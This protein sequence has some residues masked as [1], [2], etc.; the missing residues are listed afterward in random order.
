M[1][2]KNAVNSRKQDEVVYKIP[3]ECG[4]MYTGETRGNQG[5]VIVPQCGSSKIT[6]TVIKHARLVQIGQP[7]MWKPI[8]LSK[9]EK[10][11]QWTLPNSK[12]LIQK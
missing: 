6:P 12:E 9:Q 1:R 2:P 7:K 8:K 11:I 5:S 3:R 10:R 4:I